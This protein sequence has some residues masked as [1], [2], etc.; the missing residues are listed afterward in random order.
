MEK[1]YIPFV[2][3]TI[4]GHSTKPFA[5]RRAPRAG[6]LAGWKGMGESD[7]L[8][9]LDASFLHLEE[10][11]PR[12]CTWSPS[13][14]STAGRRRTARCSTTSSTAW[15]WCPA[16]AAPGR[17]APG[18]GRPRWVDDPH[19]NLEYHVRHAA[20]AAPGED[21]QL[22]A[23]A[24]RVFAQR[25][26]RGKPLWEIWLVEGLRDRPG[27]DGRAV[28]AW[29][30]LAKTHHALVDG[31]SGVDIATVLFD[32]DADGSA[33]AGTGTAPVTAPTPDGRP[34][35]PRPLPSSGQLLAD[36]LIERATSPREV[37]RS[38][39]ALARAPRRRLVAV[40]D[41]AAALGGLAWSG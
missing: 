26:D 10:S 23:L 40:R 17:G 21:P 27:R 37:V 6:G 18:P 38:V 30:L 29:A 14:S 28:P 20:L 33:V 13:S 24:G 4:H 19:L 15:P 12:T 41:A 34:W 5:V 2:Q 7:R 35:S 1:G 3:V 25:L 39:R 8:T 32:A 11:A 31:V 22:R 9:G 16:I 36:A